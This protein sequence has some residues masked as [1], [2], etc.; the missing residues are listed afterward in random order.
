MSSN[1]SEEEPFS[2]SES[3]FESDER[4]ELES[5]FS[6]GNVLLIY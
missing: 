5:S 1:E 4:I 3:E 2:E 6:S